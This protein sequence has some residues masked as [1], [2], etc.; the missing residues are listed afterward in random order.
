MPPLSP[1]LDAV[2]AGIR[3]LALD[4]DGV[5]TDGR[6]VYGEDGE[7][8][9]FD[10]KDGL[11]LT[12][13]RERDVGVAWISGRGCGATRRRARELGVRELHLGVG[14]KDA[15]LAEIQERLGIPREATAAMGD[16]LPDL[17]L[18]GRAALFCA[19]ADAVAAVRERAQ[20]VTEARGGRGAVRELCEHLLRARGELAGIAARYGA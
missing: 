19:P 11:G 16:D 7:L 5:L 1:E 3:L 14:R 2:L 20:L 12:W 18:A 4:V 15:V 8:Q 9:A 10:V 6:V 17:A 13:L